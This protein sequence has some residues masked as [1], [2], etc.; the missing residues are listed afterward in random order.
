MKSLIIYE[1]GY[2]NTENI[3]VAIA[4]A[5]GKHGKAHVTPVSSI[6]D[7]APRRGWTFW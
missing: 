3:A 6:A 1:S 5:L 7:L 4:E 2:G